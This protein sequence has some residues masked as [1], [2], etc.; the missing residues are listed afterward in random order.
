MS[1]LGY[2]AAFLTTFAFVPQALKTIR[3]RDTSGL[4]L[5]MYACLTVG[6]FLW[7]L[8]GINRQDFALIGANAVTLMLALPI[9]LIILGNTRAARRAASG[10]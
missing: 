4:S 3:T 8:H 5:A 7:L 6:I 9:F 2:I 1:E 10:K